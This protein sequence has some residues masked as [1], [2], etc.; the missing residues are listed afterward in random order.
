MVL[1][2][3]CFA[4]LSFIWSHLLYIFVPCKS[5]NNYCFYIIAF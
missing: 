4:P 1:Y 2:S 5:S 3:I